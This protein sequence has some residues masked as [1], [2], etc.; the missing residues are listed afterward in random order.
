[1]YTQIQSFS[2][3]SLYISPNCESILLQ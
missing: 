2:T 1:M 3:E